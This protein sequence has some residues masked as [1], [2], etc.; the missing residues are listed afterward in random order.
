MDATEAARIEQILE[1]LAIATAGDL[2]TRVPTYEDGEPLLIE[3]ELGI[4]ALLE[5]LDFTAKERLRQQ[6]QL[7]AQAVKLVSQQREMLMELSTPV[8]VVWPHV[9]TV[10]IIGELSAERASAMTKILL[11]QVV[12]LQATHVILDVTGASNV[13][14]QTAESLAT[15]ASA[16]QLLG[17]R[18]VMTGISPELAAVLTTCGVQLEKILTLRSVSEALAMVLRERGL[19]LKI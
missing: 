13:D 1:R 12:T 9:L 17:A 14:A 3:L 2:S 6:E 8:I 19:R 18:C 10:P 16:I 15:M 7:H 5:E 4:N 11:D